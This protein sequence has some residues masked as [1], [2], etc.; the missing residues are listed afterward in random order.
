LQLLATARAGTWCELA[1]LWDDYFGKL[2][3]HNGLVQLDTSVAGIGLGI[4]S[5]RATG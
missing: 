5:Y 3:V 2:S 4:H 1:P